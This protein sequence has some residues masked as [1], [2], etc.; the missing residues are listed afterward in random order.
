MIGGLRRLVEGANYAGPS[1]GSSSWRSSMS[2]T[3]QP[4]ALTAS[5]SRPMDPGTSGIRSRRTT[6]IEGPY[7]PAR[8]ELERLTTRLWRLVADE[9]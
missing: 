3:S 8:R 1:S 4:T 5:I 9:G 6:C 2:S 7:D